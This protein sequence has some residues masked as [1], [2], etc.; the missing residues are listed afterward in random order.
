MTNEEKYKTPEERSQAYAK[1]CWKHSCVGGGAH[2][3]E[4]ALFANSCGSPSKPRRI[5]LCFVR[6]AGRMA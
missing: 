5:S 6:S 4:T 2:V 3:K 1:F